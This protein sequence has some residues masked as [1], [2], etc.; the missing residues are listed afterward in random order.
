MIIK[1]ITIFFFYIKENKR[2]NNNLTKI[3]ITKNI[4]KL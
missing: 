2:K 3:Y 1:D 4:S